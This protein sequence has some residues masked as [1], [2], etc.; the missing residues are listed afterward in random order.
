MDTVENTV[1]ELAEHIKPSSI[2]PEV[3]IRGQPNTGKTT[4][5]LFIATLLKENI[6]EIKIS[7]EDIEPFPGI[8]THPAYQREAC[9]KLF[10]GT[11]VQL[12]TLEALPLSENVKLIHREPH[13]CCGNC[14]HE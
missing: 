1:V 6:P 13:Q 3:I 5:M 9:K 14:R 7:V 2:P 8:M 12:R 4:L 10:S 11:S